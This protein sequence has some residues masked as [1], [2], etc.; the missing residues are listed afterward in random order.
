MIMT[1]MTV[2]EPGMPITS[3][4]AL[5]GERPTVRLSQGLIATITAMAAT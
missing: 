2:A 1:L 5:N 4:V 3:S